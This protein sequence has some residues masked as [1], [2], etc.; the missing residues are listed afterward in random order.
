LETESAPFAGRFFAVR[1]RGL[2][3]RTAFIM[4]LNA[5]RNEQLKANIEPFM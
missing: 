2:A 3:M 1:A 5:L 4:G